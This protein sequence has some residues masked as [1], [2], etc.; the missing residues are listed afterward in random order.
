MK[1]SWTKGKDSVEAK[2]IKM[3]FL[4]AVILRNRLKELCLEE[5]ANSYNLSKSQ[6][7]SPNWQMLQADAVG[8]KRAMEKIISLIS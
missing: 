6:Y 4:S 7:D 2:D 1:T 8:Y 5:I 3:D